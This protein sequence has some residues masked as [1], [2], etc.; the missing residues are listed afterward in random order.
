MYDAPIFTASLVGYMKSEVGYS[1]Q[2]T[3]SLYH[4]CHVIVIY[5][6]WYGRCSHVQ[7]TLHCLKLYPKTYSVLTKLSPFHP[8]Y[9]IY[10]FDWA[11]IFS[12]R[13]GRYLFITVYRCLIRVKANLCQWRYEYLCIY[14]TSRRYL[15]LVRCI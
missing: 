1:V 4:S 14:S 9:F 11:F 6:G 5:H 3:H 8:W 13:T 12:K 7:T 2:I 15:S 10:H